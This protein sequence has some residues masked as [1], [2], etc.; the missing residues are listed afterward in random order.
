MCFHTYILNNNKFFFLK[1]NTT[2]DRIK[3]SQI[4]SGNLV[5]SVPRDLHWTSV[6]Q[7]LSI[8]IS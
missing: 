2:V 6:F 4:I 8:A 7:F 3:L 5:L 1:K